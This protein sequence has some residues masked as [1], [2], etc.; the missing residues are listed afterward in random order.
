MSNKAKRSVYNLITGFATQFVVMALGFVIP[1][2]TL[3]NFGSETNGYMSL[4]A[5]IYSY[6][7]LLEAG[8]G[9]TVLQALYAPVASNDRKT[10]SGIINAAK[11]YYRRV[12]VYY[13][14]VVIAV[15]VI[16]P[17][18]VDSDLSFTEMA[19]YFLFNGVGNVISFSVTAA[20]TQL[21]LAE[22]KNY[23]A[24]IITIVFHL[25]SQTVKIILLSIGLNIVFL[26]LCY[27]T[28]GLL[29]LLVYY[30]YY[31]K[32]YFWVDKKEKPLISRLKQRSAFFV[33]RV[34]DLVFSC[35]DVLLISVFCD[36]AMA[37]VYAIYTLIYNALTTAL[38]SVFSSVKFLLGQSYSES[39]EK[40]VLIYKNFQKILCVTAFP[41]FSTAFV[42]TIPFI[43]L[44]TQGITDADYIDNVLPFMFCVNGLLTACK[45]VPLNLINISYHAKKTV[46]RS[47]AE[48]GINLGLSILLVPFFGIRGALIGTAVALIYR[49]IDM[50]FY[51]NKKILQMPIWYELK[52][53]VVNFSVFFAIA[54]VAPKI[55]FR[56]GNY[57]D[58][59]VAGAICVTIS[60]IIYL[61]ANYITD[62]KNSNKLIKMLIKRRNKNERI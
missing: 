58:F 40:Y 42:L 23:V 32:T 30:I 60:F 39:R 21:L 57:W 59:I 20:L 44:Y 29:Q 36:L 38:S 7:A 53:Y 41:L 10:I 3:T 12:A 56:I 22:G 35:T 5:Q 61:S 37:S 31:K 8:L 33:Q 1:R 52:L 4:V 6:I 9:M 11:I 25:F 16:L 43:Q 49:V 19:L 48:A 17:L 18:L 24:S 47:I 51:T 62:I 2:L 15:S 50:L 26:Q 34:S 14:I 13:G 45:W 55:A 28:I 27:T 46:G 54:L